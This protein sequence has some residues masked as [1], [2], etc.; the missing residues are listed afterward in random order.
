MAERD[1][2]FGRVDGYGWDY[3]LTS[4][5]E[6]GRG[7][8]LRDAMLHEKL[9]RDDHRRLTAIKARLPPTSDEWPARAMHAPG[10]FPVGALDVR[11]HAVLRYRFDT[12]VGGIP[13]AEP[14]T[15]PETRMVAVRPMAGSGAR[16]MD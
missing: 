11:G 7:R 3:D 12:S 15:R 4:F 5:I 16:N 9:M 14:E 6:G 8:S 2:A 10:D 13:T 1:R